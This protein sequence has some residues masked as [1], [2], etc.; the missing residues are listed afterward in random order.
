MVKQRE[1]KTT[2]YINSIF[3]KRLSSFFLSFI[4]F[5]SFISFLLLFFFFFLHPLRINFVESERNVHYFLPTYLGGAF[6][7]LLDVSERNFFFTK[8]TAAPPPPLRMPVP[9]M[10]VKTVGSVMEK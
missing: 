8:G 5:F 3:D 10:T 1:K 9:L 2:L 4:L 7:S 6:F